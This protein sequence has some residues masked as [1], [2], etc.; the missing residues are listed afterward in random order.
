MFIRSVSLT[1]I[2]S[3]REA[4]VTFQP[5]AN[6]I[7][8]DN[9]A[10]K[11]TILEA[12]GYALFDFIPYRIE[13]IIRHGEK[14][15]EI[16]VGFEGTDGRGY[17]V[18]RSIRRK[19]GTASY[20]LHDHVGGAKLADTKNDGKEGVLRAIR[21]ILPDMGH[22]TDLSTLFQDVI[23]VPQGTI[24]SPFLETEA[25]RKRK[26]DPILGINE[27]KQA[28]DKAGEV[29]R[30]IEK[31]SQ[32]F[33]EEKASLSG[34][35]EIL[36]Q[37]VSDLGTVREEIGSLV[38]NISE[39]TKE[40]TGVRGRKT[41]L[42]AIERK[43]Q[44]HMRTIGILVDRLKTSEVREKDVSAS[45][46]TAETAL[47]MVQG[48]E[49]DYL[50]YN[51][52][53]KERLKLEQK[54]KERDDI[55]KNEQDHLRQVEVLKTKRER[56]REDIERTELELKKYP[57]VE[58]KLAAQ[59]ALE[60]KRQMLESTLAEQKERS[61]R[62]EKVKQ[63]R[64]RTAGTLEGNRKKITG[65]EQ[66]KEQAGKLDG[67][68]EELKQLEILGAELK[69]EMNHIR[70][71]RLQLGDGTC[72]FFLEPCPK[73][74]GTPEDLFSAKEGKAKGEL[75]RVRSRAGD[76]Q[77]EIGVCEKAGDELRNLQMMQVRVAELEHQLTKLEEEITELKGLMSKGPDVSDLAKVKE[78]LR[79]HGDHRG[80]HHRLVKTR[81]G[82]PELDRMQKEL[83]ERLATLVRTSDELTGKLA[84]F[85]DLENDLEQIERDRTS[86]K[87]GFETYQKNKQ[88]SE[89]VGSLTETL[90]KIKGTRTE[91]EGNLKAANAEHEQLGKIFDREELERISKRYDH[92]NHELGS[93]EGKKRN[94]EDRLEKLIAE[95]ARLEGIEKRR[96][97]VEKRLKIERTSENLMTHIR[98]IFRKTPDY[99]RKRYVEAISRDANN[100]FHE[101][102]GDNSID[103]TWDDAYGISMRS[104]KDTITFHLL[105]GGQQMSA[106]LAVRL[107]LIRRF[108][109]L[110][111]AFF[112]EPTH[113]LDDERRDNLARAFYR[114]TG[115]DQLFVISHDETFNTVIENTIS[116]RME[117]GESLITG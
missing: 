100:R 77:K 82:K 35:L 5:G 104:G 72:P 34:N 20:Y 86:H 67:L 13:D 91:I 101:L 70:E 30:V 43:I 24:I 75:S 74:T 110:K 59:I 63:E 15:G 10:G 71:S 48:S 58:Q 69:S 83:G 107:A 65:I 88:E 102:M 51:E 26:F 38:K 105:S 76:L 94:F 114:I 73:I 85:K 95:K 23:G 106:A 68:R 17:E 28:R 25:N 42:E 2:K 21:D 87:T 97:E 41:E 55:R 113:N 29:L 108:S 18:V 7:S 112:D 14:K 19:G 116:V 84:S 62:L 4:N 98:E 31:N 93:L 64:M 3:Y 6:A 78:E 11:S 45:L 52:L 117:N 50:A 37:V 79:I 80:E 39:R 53:E 12:I 60:K 32:R 96:T 8:G 9:G 47:K 99:L 103:I 115:F 89:K 92:L 1:N 61:R 109:G 81:E 90:G 44:E 33:L 40:L 46:R 66:L 36:P 57:E 22:S 54:R 111:L 49:K 56:H 16:R 27:Y